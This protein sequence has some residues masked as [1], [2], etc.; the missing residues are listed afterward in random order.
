MSNSWCL[1]RLPGVDGAGRERT[2]TIPK[3]TESNSRPE[4]SPGQEISMPGQLKSVD[5]DN[6]H[7]NG[8]NVKTTTFRLTASSVVLSTIICRLRSLAAESSLSV[9]LSLLFYFVVG[10]VAVVVVHLVLEIGRAFWLWRSAELEAP[11]PEPDQV[12][13]AQGRVQALFGIPGSLAHEL[14]LAPVPFVL[15]ERPDERGGWDHAGIA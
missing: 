9:K 3:P 7:I 1:K 2:S 11:A 10:E 15:E 12:G 8:S 5:L 13:H 4:N 6:T 14:A